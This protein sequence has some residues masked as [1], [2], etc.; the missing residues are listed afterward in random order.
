M[1]FKKSAFS[2][3]AF[4]FFLTFLSFGAQAQTSQQKPR[5][6]FFHSHSCNRC[7]KVIENFMPDFQKQFKGRLEIEYRDISEIEN[8]KLLISLMDKYGNKKAV[9]LP[10]TFLANTLLVG[11]DEVVSNLSDLAQNSTLTRAPVENKIPDGAVNLVA[12]FKEFKP[13]AITSAGLIDGINPCAFTVIVFFISF[14]TLQGYRKN[15]LVAIGLV[16]I[17]AVFITYLAIGLGMFGFLYQ[18]K[19]FWIMARIINYSIGIFSVILGI[20]AMHD[21]FKFKKTGESQGLLLQLPKPI[22]NQIHKLIGSHYRLRDKEP[23]AKKKHIFALIISALVTGFLVS[24]LEAVC[25]GQV[26]LPTITFVLKTSTFKLQALW[27]L[28]LYNIMF[29]V[30]LFI[31][32]ILALLG[33][34]S[35]QFSS[36]LKRRMLA[37]K[38]LMVVLFFSLGIFLLW[39]A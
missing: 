24:L 14:L 37:I 13:W 16:Y 19:G 1:S 9:N 32:F 17:L 7:I 33:V 26:Y 34:T 21:F 22:K 20:A 38:F 28:L 6:I 18:V 31:I 36:F 35:E 23:S 3:A 11:Q 12:R 2:T 8:Y 10:T 15:E 39:K 5:L 4:L 29:V 25:T 27:Y 30:P